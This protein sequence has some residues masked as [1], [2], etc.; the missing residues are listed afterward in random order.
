[1]TPH[2]DG[3]LARIGG[4]VYRNR[5]VS[6]NYRY[7]YVAGGVR[8]DVD[9]YPSCNLFVRRD[10]LM[11]IGGYRTDFWPGED[12]LLC[13]DI[14]DAGQRIVYDPWVVVYHHRRPLFLPHV[15]QL[16][17]YAFHR[18]YFCKRYPSNSRRLS[19]F[20]PTL[21]CLALAA[22]ALVDALVWVAAP[23]AVFL[24][25]LHAPF[26]LYAGLVLAGSFSFR[27]ATWLLTAAGIFVT[28]VTYGVRFLQGLL[29]RRAPC[30]F[31]GAD[32]GTARGRRRSGAAAGR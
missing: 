4:R 9:D 32:H 7:R 16:G 20:V 26:L 24:W 14:I 17:R 1:V 22:T 23:S 10:L 3:Y 19:Y 15:R 6:G 18:G 21:F 29:A 12:T 13:K 28:H 2:N 27:P 8:R 30:E 11:K 25:C 5:L 31:I